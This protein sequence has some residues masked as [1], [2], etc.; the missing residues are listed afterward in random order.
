MASLEAFQMNARRQ[1]GDS[2]YEPISVP[3]IDDD[4][5]ERVVVMEY[6]GDGMFSQLVAFISLGSGQGVKQLSTFYA[7]LE[8]SFPHEDDFDFLV[9]KLRNEELTYDQMFDIVQGAMELW[10]TFP[11]KSSSASPATPRKTGTRSTGR[12][13]GKGSIQPTSRPAGSTR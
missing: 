8:K 1:A 7:M 10:S 5:T 12:S 11:T 6:P 9:A 13:P 3:L 2:E 4:G